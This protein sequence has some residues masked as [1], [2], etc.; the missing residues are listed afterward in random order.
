M[1]ELPDNF[2]DLVITDP[3]FN[4]MNKQDLKFK[5]RTDIRQDVKFD[6]FESYESYLTFIDRWVKIIEQKLR[7]NS[8]MY[9]FFAIQYIT[10]LMN[11]CLKYGLRYKGVII[12]HKTNPAPKIRKNG[13]LSSTESVL[14]MTKGKPTFNFLGQNKMH[15]FIETP[16]CMGNERLKDEQKLNKIGNFATLHPTQKPLELY[17]H[18]I[19]VS[20]NVDDLISDPFAGTGT[21]NVAS[22]KLNRYCLGIEI[23]EK[24]SHYAKE[25][26][27]SASS[28]IQKF[29]IDKWTKKIE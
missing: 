27:R 9:I 21:A 15:N 10:D 2:I 26:I 3:P 23:D 5:H 18:F 22:K 13:Y 28:T 14:F 12:W 16:I 24:Y 11:I 1:E 8:S 29:R 4:V 25:R 17:E 20:S 19:E 6:Q 7:M